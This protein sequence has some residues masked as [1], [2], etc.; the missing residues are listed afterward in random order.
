[1][2]ICIRH[3][4]DDYSNA[5]HRHDHRLTMIGEKQIRKRVKELLEKYGKPRIV[6]CSPFKRTKQSLKILLEELAGYKP[7]IIYSK[8]LSKYFGR[9]LPEDASIFPETYQK[10]LPFYENKDDF[11]KRVD[12]FCNELID[13]EYD[14]KNNVWC[15]THAIIYKRLANFFG[16]EV[17]KNVPFAA[18][19]RIG[20]E[21]EKMT[22]PKE[23]VIKSLKEKIP[24]KKELD[25]PLI[26]DFVT[27]RRG[28][29]KKKVK[30]IKKKPME[31]T[32]LAMMKN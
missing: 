14:K 16:K 18:A 20:Y 19:V 31:G 8:G 28:K 24:S 22:T 4:D 7:K 15:I 6:Y 11:H 30:K 12:D 9:T 27:E 1:M 17:K 13:K 21:G 23:G 2:I 10:D 26:K 3:G 25:K 29:K 32:V 5:T